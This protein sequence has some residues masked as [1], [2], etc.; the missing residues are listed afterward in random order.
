M[1]YCQRGVWSAACRRRLQRGSPHRRAGGPGAAGG[2]AR[3]GAGHGTGSTSCWS[4]P[5]AR[6]H[7]TAAGSRRSTT[8]SSSCGSGATMIVSGFLLERFPVL[9]GARHLV[10]DAAGPFLLENL[11][12]HQTEPAPR[13]RR[14][15]ADE[16]AVLSR[17]LAAADLVLVR[18]RSPARSDARDHA[19]GRRAAPGA[20]RLGREPRAVLPDRPVRSDGARWSPSR[21]RRTSRPAPSRLA[22]RALGLARPGLPRRG[23]RA[24]RGAREPT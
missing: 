3:D 19:R 14:V 16:A 7:P 21:T 10:V 2:R 24:R 18:T 5:R 13:R 15:L 23:D 6:A 4:R 9:A 20:H 17:L 12:V 8:S 11:V 1:I 22:G